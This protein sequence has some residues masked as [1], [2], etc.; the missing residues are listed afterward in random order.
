MTDLDLF[1]LDLFEKD[2]LIVDY[3]EINHFFFKQYD[4]F[5]LSLK[6]K[7]LNFFLC[8]QIPP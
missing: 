6:I 1:A 3:I 8:T 7:Q 4:D 2:D 5:S